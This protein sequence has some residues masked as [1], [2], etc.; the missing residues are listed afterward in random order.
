MVGTKFL[1]GVTQHRVDQDQPV[2]QSGRARST[3]TA[4][5]SPLAS[6]RIALTGAPPTP[7]PVPIYATN[8]ANFDQPGEP[9]NPINPNP[10]VVLEDTVD[11]NSD[12]GRGMCEIVYKMAPKAKIGFATA[13]TGEV[14]FANNI[15]ALSGQFPGVPNTQPGFQGRRYRG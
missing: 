7:P 2:L 6:C 1:Q 5:A 15:R 11:A 9:N 13:F 12:E 4:P 10:V 3:T 14:G 8:L